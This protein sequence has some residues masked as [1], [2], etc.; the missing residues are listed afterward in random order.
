M[1]R[2]HFIASCSILLLA[3]FPQLYAAEPVCSQ[4]QSTAFSHY[5]KLNVSDGWFDVYQLP[6]NVYA[7]YESRQEQEVL[8]YLIVGSKRAL[9]FDSGLGM[10]RV[11]GHCA[12]FTHAL[13]S[14][15]RKRGVLGH[16][17]G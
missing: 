7:F 15:W 17:C 11:A 9:L 8:S 4:P 12:Q 6:G 2:K 1:P 16:L 5:K 3:L 14:R 13:R 10:D